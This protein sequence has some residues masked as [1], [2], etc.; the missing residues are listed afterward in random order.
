MTNDTQKETAVKLHIYFQEHLTDDEV[1]EK[2]DKMV[3]G[4][5]HQIYEVEQQEI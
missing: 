4:M 2:I 3:K 1:Y 5:P